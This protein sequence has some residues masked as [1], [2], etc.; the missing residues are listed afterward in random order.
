MLVGVFSATSSIR[1]IIVWYMAGVLF[2]IDVVT[3][4]QTAEKTCSLGNGDGTTHS[5]VFCGSFVIFSKAFS[6]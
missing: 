4:Q 1:S 5:T 6:G 2:S 3:P